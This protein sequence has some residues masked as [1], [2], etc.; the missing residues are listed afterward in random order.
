M[1][2]TLPSNV[3]SIE[4]ERKEAADASRLR[5]EKRHPGEATESDDGDATSDLL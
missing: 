4:K 3:T 5:E 2:P 1:G